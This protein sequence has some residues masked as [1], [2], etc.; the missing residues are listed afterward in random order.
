MSYMK[1]FKTMSEL[2]LFIFLRNSTRL[3]DL[4]ALLFIAMAT[5]LFY[6][7]LFLARSGALTADHIV[8][9]YPW[10]VLLAQ[11]LRQGTLPFWTPLVQCGFPLVAEGQVGAFYLPNL[12]LY[13]LLPIQ[14]AYSYSSALHFLIAGWGTY[15]YTRQMKLIPIAAFISAFIYLFGTSYGGAYYNI[16]SLKTL[17]WFPWMLYLFERFYHTQKV[18]YIIVLG[19]LSSL[20]ILA[21]YLQV[22][23]SALFI[24]SLYALFRLFIFFDPEFM[25]IRDRILKLIGF[26]FSL[27]LGILISLPQLLLTFHLAMLSNR[28]LAEEAYAYV[29][30]LSPGALGTLVFPLLQGL[31]RGNSLYLGVFSIFLIFFSIFAFKNANEKRFFYLWGLLSLVSL[32]WALGQWSPL[33]VGFVKLT[34]FYSFRTP[35]KFLIFICFGLSVFCGIGFQKAWRGD[36][37]P[38]FKIIVKKVSKAYVILSLWSLSILSGTYLV[39]QHA[40]SV[41]FKIGEWFVLHFVYQKAG[42]PHEINV[43][44]DKLGQALAYASSVLSPEH[45][46]SRWCYCVLLTG[47]LF[48]LV[49][50]FFKTSMR[51]WLLMGSLFLGLDLFV[52]SFFDI[53]TDFDIYENVL[54]PSPITQKLQTELSRTGPARIFGFRSGDETLPLIPSIN[55]LYGI[56]DIGFYSPLVFSR[57]YETIGQFGNINDSTMQQNPSKEFVLDHLKLLNFLDVG[58]ILSKQKLDHPDLILLENDPRSQTFLYKN[59]GSH[60]RA[61]FVNQYE[62]VKDWVQL[63]EKLMTPGFD[64]RKV[65]LLETNEGKKINDLSSITEE[66][67]QA[68][69]QRT[70]QSVSH[71]QWMVETNQP[72]FF[73]LSNVMFPG[74]CAKINGKRTPILAVNGMFQAVVIQNPGQYVIVFEYSRRD[75]F[76]VD[77]R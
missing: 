37:Y 64:P 76:K 17:A 26:V 59:I 27:I 10:A 74:W 21:G 62:F 58:F 48:A 35:A 72:G 55:M 61:F 69:L 50:P 16:T 41:I 42:H 67:P 31:F 2:P 57:Y 4:F 38:D 25:Q 19:L 23:V 13:S 1:L 40:R 43:Y 15:A 5:F 22:A 39:L 66:E 75:T 12:I 51:R 49:M 45:P 70:A 32:L 28:A 34:H 54:K 33:Y 56:E 44:R 60:A 36:S 71:E 65:V 46:W 3:K 73:V 52:F 77:L 14:W 47:I 24:F 29:G 63:K 68:V 30:S 53:K 18:R 9:H 11:S 20:S 7:E 8:Q 6:P